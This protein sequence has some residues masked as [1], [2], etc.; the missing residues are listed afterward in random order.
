M[1]QSAGDICAQCKHLKMKEY[2]DH[3]RVGLGRRMGYDNDYR[4]LANP[5]VSW[6]TRAC[7]K[8]AAADN[9]AERRAWIERQQAKAAPI[10]QE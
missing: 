6:K 4:Q 9:I 2:P 8:F 5:I 10:K 1:T 7:V 3:A